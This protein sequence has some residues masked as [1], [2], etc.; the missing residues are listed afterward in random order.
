MPELDTWPRWGRTIARAAQV[1][2]YALLVTAGALGMTWP[3]GYA[4]EG[5][6]HALTNIG[7]A[8]TALAATVCLLAQLAHRWRVELVAIP[9]VGVGLTA[10]AT[11]LLLYV[12][13]AREWLIFTA[14]IGALL[15]GLTA[16]GVSLLVFERRTRT[17]KQGATA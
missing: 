16:R 7:G 4:L 8:I 6:A 2:A 15:A 14:V 17:A 13:P 9:W 11:V 1:A 3:P 12:G 5:W 10:Y